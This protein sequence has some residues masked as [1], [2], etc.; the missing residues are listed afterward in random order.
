MTQIDNNLPALLLAD[1]G[2]DLLNATGCLNWLLRVIH[3]DRATCPEC[4]HEIQSERQLTAF[5]EMR[6]VCCKQCNRWFDCKTGTILQATTLPPRRI[7]LL[8]LLLGIGLPVREIAD[9]I[10]IHETT[11]RDWRDRLCP[12]RLP[13]RE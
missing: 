6:R 8:A 11:V 4:G 2:P 3:G 1:L 7:V 9:R 5:R 12:A 10:G 13:L